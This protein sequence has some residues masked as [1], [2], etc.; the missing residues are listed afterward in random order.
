[1]LQGTERPEGPPGSGA[2]SE[3]GATSLEYGFMISLVAGVVAVALTP[4]G[5]A[6]LGMFQEGLAAFP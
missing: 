4:F 2:S 1:M 6:V 3:R 5:A